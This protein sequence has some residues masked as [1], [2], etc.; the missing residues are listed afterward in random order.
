MS[1][2]YIPY[3]AH[4]RPLYQSHCINH[5]DTHTHTE[6]YL[7]YQVVMAMGY[8]LNILTWSHLAFFYWSTCRQ[9][10]MSS[11]LIGQQARGQQLW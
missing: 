2:I 7:G 3:Q 10:I 4:H 6:G 8:G 11:C 5:I 1:H 9:P